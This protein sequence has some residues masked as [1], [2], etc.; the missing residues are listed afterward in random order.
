MTRRRVRARVLGAV[1]G[2]ALLALGAAAG[3]SHLKARAA[4]RLAE[5]WSEYEACLVGGPLEDGEAPSE[6]MR[7]IELAAA[8]TPDR[9][10]WPE[11]CRAP[12]RRIKSLLSSWPLKGKNELTTLYGPLEWA[13]GDRAAWTENAYER[14]DAQWQRL[15]R[16]ELP[17]VASSLT[18]SPLVAP[19]LL[20]VEAAR[21]GPPMTHRDQQ[22][23][24]RVTDPVAHQA[25]TLLLST[26]EPDTLCRFEAPAAK[27]ACHPLP[28]PLVDSLSSQIV[29][30]EQ[31]AP[32]LIQAVTMATGRSRPGLFVVEGERAELVEPTL[33]DDPPA[34]VRA[35]GEIL[36]L[37]RVS[38][39]A[40]SG[41][42]LVRRG[43][44]RQP[45]E[46]VRLEAPPEATLAGGGKLHIDLVRDLV[47]WTRTDE[48]G[49]DVMLR[50]QRVP[51]APA[52]PPS[53]VEVGLVPRDGGVL[54]ACRTDV[55]TAFLWGAASG[56]GR[57]AMVRD[58]GERIVSTPVAE[59]PP[60]ARMACAGATA[61]LVGPSTESRILRV[62]CADRCVPAR[63]EPLHL[64]VEQWGRVRAAPMGDDVLVTWSLGGEDVIPRDRGVTYLLRAPLAALHEATARPLFDDAAR[65]GI[66]PVEL[67]L[68][69][70]PE[71]TTLVASTA[72]ASYAAHVLADGTVRAAVAP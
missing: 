68:F 52:S 39:P 17:R 29:S 32:S 57:S 27:G 50:A 58:L 33:F 15:P 44:A 63:S 30:A 3:V 51:P 46:D 1:A 35:D 10:G 2:A 14:M 43:R 48:P 71:F 9:G 38:K 16:S 47:V 67:D 19:R 25:L 34:F 72:K 13:E 26:D 69:P 24:P 55:M 56:G 66:E 59:V 70:R 37:R 12:A 4:R 64:L 62:D 45:F 18:T 60:D 53:H 41:E 22:R 7:R 5:A 54:A 61:S 20:S 23:F 8:P 21:I 42:Y 28:P 36:V 40:P 49:D 11:R 6:R 65:G 31:G